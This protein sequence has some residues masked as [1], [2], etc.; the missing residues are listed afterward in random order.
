MVEPDA[1]EQDVRHLLGE[2]LVRLEPERNSRPG[3]GGALSSASSDGP[4]AA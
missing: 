3:N 2:R 4:P 1:V